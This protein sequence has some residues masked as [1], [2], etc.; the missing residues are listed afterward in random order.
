LSA[1]FGKKLGQIVL[2]N[3]I[4]FAEQEMIG[5]PEIIYCSSLSRNSLDPASWLL[6]ASGT[7]SHNFGQKMADGFWYVV[8]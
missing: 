4:I 8:W 7:V 5:F 3:V 2:V 6:L 1:F